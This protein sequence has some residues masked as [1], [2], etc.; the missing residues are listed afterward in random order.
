M[1]FGSFW[2]YLFLYLC[3]YKQ[4][5][6]L[7][8]TKLFTSGGKRHD[9]DLLD[10]IIFDQFWKKHVKSLVMKAICV[11]FFLVMVSEHMKYEMGL[12]LSYPCLRKPTKIIQSLG[13]RSLFYMQFQEN[14][15]CWSQILSITLVSFK[16]YSSFTPLDSRLLLLMCH[17][18]WKITLLVCLC[19]C[20]VHG[21]V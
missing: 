8:A 17:L 14:I 18:L 15:Q 11:G 2:L 10:S 7:P 1:S 13:C 12:L 4:A 21:L 20:G 9:R 19:V 5:Y 6:L 3:E 16:M